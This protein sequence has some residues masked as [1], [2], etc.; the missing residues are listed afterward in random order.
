MNYFM[1]GFAAELVKLSFNPQGEVAPAGSSGKDAKA[2]MARH[3]GSGARTGNKSGPL[4][5]E[6]AP[7]R[8]YAPTAVTIP[9]DLVA[10]N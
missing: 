5:T 6:P 7:R 10:G 8:P 4:I 1:N 2:I 9:N 3:Q